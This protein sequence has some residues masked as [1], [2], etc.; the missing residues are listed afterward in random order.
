MVTKIDIDID[1]IFED[2]QNEG[3]KAIYDMP[4]HLIKDD[5]PFR[6][7][8]TYPVGS[9]HRMGTYSDYKEKGVNSNILD[10]VEKNN[11]WLIYTNLQYQYA[12]NLRVFYNEKKDPHP[13]YL[14]LLDRMNMNIEKS[15]CIFS[16]KSP[17]LD[18][19]SHVDKY[20]PEAFH[21]ILKSNDKNLF[22]YGDELQYCKNVKEKE[23]WLLKPQNLHRVVNLS[24]NE[25]AL[26]MI[27]NRMKD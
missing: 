15:E 20:P 19:H 21:L 24:E 9:Y 18:T 12:T 4:S 5:L 16:Y 17:K 2:L 27:I 14:K 13:S 3:L 22:Y 26:H 11:K 7:A 25:T 10:V 23:I 6:I 8:T 1:D